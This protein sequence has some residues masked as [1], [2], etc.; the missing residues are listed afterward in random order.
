MKIKNQNVLKALVITIIVSALF[1]SVFL[2]PS[3]RPELK[4]GELVVCLEVDG[5]TF[6]PVKIRESFDTG[7][8]KIFAVIDASGVKARDVWRFIWKNK[9]TGEVIADSTGS[10]SEIESGYMEGYLSNFI[11]PGEEGGIIGEPGDYSVD[12]YHGGQLISST[13]FVIEAP[14]L[15]II[16]VTLSK[17]V[18]DQGKPVEIFGRFYPDDMI[19][20]SV[21]LNCKKKDDSISVKWYRGEEELL[22]EEQFTIEDDYYLEGYVVFVIS[23]DEPWPLGDYN[24]EVFHNSL[25]EGSYSFEIVRKEMADACFDQNKVY[26]SED[27]KFSIGYPDG[28][29]YEEE[30]IENGLEVA[31]FPEPDYIDVRMKMRVLE[32]GYFPD[33][34]EYSDFA[35]SIVKDLDVEILNDEAEVHKTESSAEIDDTEYIQINYNYPGEGENG[36]DIDLIFINK[37]SKLYLFLKISA[38]YYKG[39]ADKVYDSMLKSLQLE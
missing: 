28:W 3:C 6:A 31:F 18:D 5:D 15:E 11:V 16:E 33:K 2:V 4:F 36:W 20:A 38:M 13:D 32:K 30:D 35:D 9:D 37:N 10:Y 19:N 21:K 23:N 1:V 8:K 27:Y 12:F 29:S 14:E 24:L 7:D 26:K 17:G 34:K 22:G 25:L 39:F